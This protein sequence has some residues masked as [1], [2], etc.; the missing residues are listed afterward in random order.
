M[1]SNMIKMSAQDAQVASV[2]NQVKKEGNGKTLENSK[3]LAASLKKLDKAEK[4]LKEIRA[5][6]PNKTQKAPV[7]KEEKIIQLVAHV[8]PEKRSSYQKRPYL[9]PSYSAPE[10]ENKESN[11]IALKT[12]SIDK[13]G[14]FQLWNAKA[15][16]QLIGEWISSDKELQSFNTDDIEKKFKLFG[17]GVTDIS[18]NACKKLEKDGRLTHSKAKNGKRERYVYHVVRK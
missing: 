4:K 15:A 1:T 6:V 12:L 10:W 13:E 16:V 7:K 14:N 5:K 2:I 3:V 11:L 17:G 8:S 18:R 9:H